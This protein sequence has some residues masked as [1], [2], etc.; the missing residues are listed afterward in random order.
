M[1]CLVAVRSRQHSLEDFGV[2]ARP[3]LSM[4]FLSQNHVPGMAHV[5]CPQE[6]SEV[7]ILKD[8][9]DKISSLTAW[10]VDGKL[11]GLGLPLH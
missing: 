1:V 8:N 2:E 9:L 5:T 6:S 3:E 7:E 4:S 11:C 10:D